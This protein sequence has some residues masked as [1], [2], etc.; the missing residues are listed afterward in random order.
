MDEQPLDLSIPKT[1]KNVVN[2]QN[3]KTFF[4]RTKRYLKAL[5]PCGVCGKS[6]DR[7]SLL[8]RHIRTH[9]GEL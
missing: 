9:T 4:V 1:L 2:V 7:P 5:L 6:F 3:K 8:K